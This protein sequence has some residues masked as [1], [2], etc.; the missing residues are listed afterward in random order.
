MAEILNTKSTDLEVAV[1]FRGRLSSAW[2]ALVVRLAGIPSVFLVL[3]LLTLLDVLPSPQFLNSMEEATLSAKAVLARETA[4][5]DWI[6][7]GDSTCLQ[8]FDP[9]TFR[10]Q[11]GESALNLGLWRHMTLDA[12]IAL[13]RASP[14]LQEA[15]GI[16]LI[17]HPWSLRRSASPPEAMGLL[18][19]AI[20]GRPR[21]PAGSLAWLSAPIDSARDR[22]LN[23]FFLVPLPQPYAAQ[24]GHARR[25]FEDLKRSRGFLAAPDRSLAKIEG[26]ADYGV[27][28]ALTDSLVALRAIAE[29]R[30]ILIALSPTPESV[31]LSDTHDRY[32]QMARWLESRLAPAHCLPLPAVLPDSAFVDSMHLRPVA[33]AEWQNRLTQQW[34]IA[35]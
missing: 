4:H 32:A 10:M 23:R 3:L 9:E 25:F 13:L 8:H 31:A 16:L 33:R 17:V 30:R 12:G 2:L 27:N 24:H 15:R 6:A 22:L 19:A 5:A 14:A 34:P 11:T 21:P 35:D 7:L 1:R 28:P 18:Q 20:S 29:E 26:R